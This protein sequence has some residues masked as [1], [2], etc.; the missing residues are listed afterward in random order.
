MTHELNVWPLLSYTNADWGGCHDS[1]R[2]TSG[3]CVF[4]S[5]NLISWSSKRQ[6]TLSMSSAEA[7][8]RGVAN[9]VETCC[10]HNL[11]FEL[12]CSIS[13]ATLVYCNHVSAVYFSGNHVHHQHTKHIEMDIH[14]IREKVKRC[15][16]R[17]LHVLS[18]YQFAISSLR[19]FL[20]LCLM[21]SLSLSV[22]KPLDSTAVVSKN[23]IF[24]YF[25]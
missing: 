8:Y 17:V 6:S 25:H 7:G 10:T 16:V 1:R 12:T 23:S 5:G 21:I 3:Y 20:R 15:E 19:D 24:P 2:S 11:L 13:T 14:F 9:V 18:H 22:Y 4:L